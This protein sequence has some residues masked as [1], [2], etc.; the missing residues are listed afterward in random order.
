MMEF[1]FQSDRQR[2]RIKINIFEAEA[3][4]FERTMRDILLDYE[5]DEEVCHVKMIDLMCE[6]LEKYGC[7]EGVKIF[8]EA[9][10]HHS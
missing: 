2:R 5:D 8:R 9:S 10:K 4:H 6:T 7:Y 1:Y 3:E